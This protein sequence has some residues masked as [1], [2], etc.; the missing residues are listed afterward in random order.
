MEKCLLEYTDMKTNEIS[1]DEQLVS[2]IKL[3]NGI[4]KK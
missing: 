3:I 1:N 4:G 2:I